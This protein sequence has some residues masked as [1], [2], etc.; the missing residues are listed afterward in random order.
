MGHQLALL[1][2]I[3][4]EIYNIEVIEGAERSMLNADI[5]IN[6]KLLE[7]CYIRTEDMEEN[8]PWRISF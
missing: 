5:L 3:F 7:C 1:I 2:T 4:K 6:A 8:T